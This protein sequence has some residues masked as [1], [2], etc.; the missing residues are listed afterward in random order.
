MTD[1]LILTPPSPPI[2]PDLDMAGFRTRHPSQCNWPDDYYEA[3]HALATEQLE[4]ARATVAK[5][6]AEQERV[7]LVWQSLLPRALAALASGDQHQRDTV[8]AGMMTITP[9]REMLPA[10]LGAANGRVRALHSRVIE[11]NG[12]R[13]WRANE[14]ARAQREA[15]ALARQ[16]AQQAEE[17]RKTLARVGMSPEQY[18]QRVAAYE[19]QKAEEAARLAAQQQRRAEEAARLE[20]AKAQAEAEA[21]ALLNGGKATKK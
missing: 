3:A 13:R 16:K 15:E 2:T 8:T 10:I 1:E 4:A 5:V 21:A 6:E 11:L 14:A 12:Y 17:E 9:W 18:A 7:N 20:A 19:A